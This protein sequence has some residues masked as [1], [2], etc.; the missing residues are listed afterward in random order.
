MLRIMVP[1]PHL[2]RL[3]SPFERR[4]FERSQTPQPGKIPPPVARLGE[5]LFES[6]TFQAA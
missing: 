2:S 6:L 4:P 3:L 5:L 1:E